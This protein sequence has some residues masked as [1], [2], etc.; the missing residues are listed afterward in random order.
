MLTNAVQEQISELRWLVDELGQELDALATTP[1]PQVHHFLMCNLATK[2]ALV[3]VQVRAVL[4]EPSHDQHLPAD[5]ARL[6]E[7]SA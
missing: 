3:A 4:S 2:I 6:L 5:A 1:Y 7:Q